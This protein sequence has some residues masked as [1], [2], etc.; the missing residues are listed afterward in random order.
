[1]AVIGFTKE[2]WREIRCLFLQKKENVVM[3]NASV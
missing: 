1:M 3:K 2:E